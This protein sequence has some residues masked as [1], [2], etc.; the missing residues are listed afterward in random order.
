[1]IVAEL[2]LGTITITIYEHLFLYYYIVI[3]VI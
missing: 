1:M 2:L 3:Y